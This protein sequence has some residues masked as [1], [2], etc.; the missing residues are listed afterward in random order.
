VALRE[1]EVETL[2]INLVSINRGYKVHAGVRI[3]DV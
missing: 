2:T 3:T 1:P